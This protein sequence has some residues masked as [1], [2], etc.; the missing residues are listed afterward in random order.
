MLNEGQL[1]T[2]EHN[3]GSTVFK[4]MM[5]YPEEAVGSAEMLA[6]IFQNLWCHII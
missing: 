4:K 1:C 2:E 5:V 6:T 3:V